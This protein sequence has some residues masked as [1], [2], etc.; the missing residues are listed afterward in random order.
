MGRRLL[1]IADKAHAHSEVEIDVTKC[2][3]IFGK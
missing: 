3:K 2:D 1:D